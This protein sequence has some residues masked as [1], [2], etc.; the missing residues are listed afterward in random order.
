MNKRQVRQIL[1]DTDFVHTGGSAEELRVAEYLAE[2]SRAIGAGAHLEPF[3]VEMADMH[4]ARLTVTY[5]N[6]TTAEVPCE[7]FR[8]CGS[9]EI[10]APFV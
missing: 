7:G 5:A 9:G 8:L 3:Q 6:G 2:Q 4:A 10:D 1:K